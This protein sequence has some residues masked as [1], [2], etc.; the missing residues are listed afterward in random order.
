MEFISF[1]VNLIDPFAPTF[2]VVV[3]FSSFVVMAFSRSS[4]MLSDA[5][6]RIRRV[7]SSCSFSSGT[8]WMASKILCNSRSVKNFYSGH[9]VCSGAALIALNTMFSFHCLFLPLNIFVCA[10]GS[11]RL[12]RLSELYLPVRK[13][14]MM[15]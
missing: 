1:L 15:V 10:A 12:R 8:Y 13:I 7:T 11:V 2:R 5:A 3:F 4:V 14:N 6:L 9:A